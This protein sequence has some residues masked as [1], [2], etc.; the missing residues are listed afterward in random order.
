[1]GYVVFPTPLPAL[2]DLVAL[3]CSSLT[4]QPRT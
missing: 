1:M 2:G 3:G 4:F